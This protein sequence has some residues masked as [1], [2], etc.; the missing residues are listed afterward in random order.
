MERVEVFLTK[1]AQ[2]VFKNAIV[3]YSENEKPVNLNQILEKNKCTFILEKEYFLDYGT[4]KK[5]HLGMDFAT[6]KE[7]LYLLIK[8]KKESQ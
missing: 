1:K 7:A 8:A 4:N 2:T 3:K 6:A 5:I